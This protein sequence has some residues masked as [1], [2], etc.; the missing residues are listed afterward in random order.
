M[1]LLFWRKD[2]DDARH[3]QL[4]AQLTAIQD[5]LANLSERLAADADEWQEISDQLA[6][7]ARL[8]Y[9]SSQE[10][11]GRLADVDQRLA[12]LA[13][14]QAETVV[15]EETLQSLAWQRQYLVDILLQQLDEL[16][17]ACAGL[18]GETGAA[19]RELLT[20]WAERLVAA[21][22]AVGL[23]ELNV[24]GQ[25]FDPAVAN[26]V[27]SIRRRQPTQGTV[28]Y[29]VAEVVRRGF[30]DGAG[31]VV[32]KAEVITYQEGE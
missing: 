23:Y 19:W 15:R 10:I 9:K 12:A 8:Q 17:R 29:E 14:A 26:A 16:D 24:T 27:G 31:R 32:R 3:E 21:L 1:N 5:G 2:K 4:A 25:T 30:R 6:K 18:N 20:T 7:L 22:E 11:T 28:P 13:A